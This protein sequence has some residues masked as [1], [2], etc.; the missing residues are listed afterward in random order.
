VKSKVALFTVWV[1]FVYNERIS[2]AIVCAS[3]A[4]SRRFRGIEER[5]A[6]LGAEEVEFVV[7]SLAQHRII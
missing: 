1:T 2:L 4:R 3:S 7:E 5:I 6:A